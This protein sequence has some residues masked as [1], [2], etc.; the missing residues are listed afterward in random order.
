M[1][2]RGEVGWTADFSAAHKLP[3]TDDIQTQAARLLAVGFI[4][5]ILNAY[6][7]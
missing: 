5:L 1:S 6:F 7:G 4:S 2:C 3:T